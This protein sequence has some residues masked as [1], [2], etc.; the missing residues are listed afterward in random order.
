MADPKQ[1]FSDRQSDPEGVGPFT[2]SVPELAPGESHTINLRERSGGRFVV[3]SPAGYDSLTIKNL[4]ATATLNLTVNEA[5]EYP[6]APNTEPSIGL[7]GQYRYD[8]TNTEPDGGATV[9]AGEVRLT[10]LKEAFGADAQA[11]KSRSE[12]P[13]RK[14]VRHFTGI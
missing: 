4:N 7:N 9:S 13:V 10:V 3:L 11:R 5:T 2:F 6:I 1:T 8:I 14:V 12:G